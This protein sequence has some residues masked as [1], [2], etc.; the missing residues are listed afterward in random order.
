MEL[1]IGSV[2]DSLHGAGGTG[3]TG[4]ADG[5]LTLGA[6]WPPEPVGWIDRL[7]RRAGPR[8][9]L[10]MYAWISAVAFA[11]GLMTLTA[12]VPYLDAD[13]DQVRELGPT[14]AVANTAALATVS[15]LSRRRFR[16]GIE[17]LAGQRSPEL[18][19]RAW[20]SLVAEL[21]RFLAQGVG[22]FTL[23]SIPA[24]VLASGT[25]E[26]PWFGALVVVLAVEMTIVLA[27]LLD[28]LGVELLIRPAV[29]DVA[30]HLPPGFEPSRS[31]ISLRWRVV[32][33]MTVT[34]LYGVGL[35]TAVGSTTLSPVVK[36]ST[37]LGFSVLM[38]VTLVLFIATLLS[39]AVVGPMRDLAD[40]MRRVRTGEL[41]VR[42][43]LVT[44]D[45]TGSLAVSFN[46]MARGLAE[47]EVLRSAVGQYVSPDVV[48]RILAEGTTLAGEEVVVTVMFLDI[49]D[50]TATA[51]RQRP[52]ETVGMLND[53]FG[54][55]VPIVV[56]HGGHTN[57]FLGDGLL[58]VFGAPERLDDH[59]DR[60][61]AA[62]TAIA[63][64]AD[65]PGSSGLRIGIGLNS[66]PVV[67][68][69][70]GGGG[71]LEYSVIGDTVNVASRVE[72]LT[73]SLGDTV[74]LTEAT[75][76]LLSTGHPPLA[77]RGA[78]EV[79]GKAASVQVHAPALD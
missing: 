32:A 48:E 77:P 11:T 47:R 39:D 23:Y 62:A 40:G 42:V 20:D 78:V 64:L 49:R 54:A 68:G 38:T 55:V 6:E 26:L 33:G 70:V 76:Q 3:E 15:A 73:K 35:G 27:A 57:K 61:L 21:P 72:T 60:A 10:V 79:R 7:Y 43:P 30:R 28:L 13:W 1:L 24:A 12:A 22:V 59:A 66:G 19:P 71:R 65:Q 58:A 74:L 45:E 37:G 9:H 41:D 52:E 75:K 16:P 29:R 14:W 25:L 69:S 36:V 51:E 53:Y 2:A 44:A 8:Y 31:S 34:S 17:W 67:V 56:E 18:A 50:F 46:D 63:R 5:A 4:R